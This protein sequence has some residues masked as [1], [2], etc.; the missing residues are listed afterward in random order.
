MYTTDYPEL[1]NFFETFRIE[2]YKDAKQF[3]TAVN[4]NFPVPTGG[5][6]SGKVSSVTHTRACKLLV[7]LES[8]KADEDK[9]EEEALNTIKERNRAL[10]ADWLERG[11]I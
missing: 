8:A 5:F 2:S 9:R 11:L 10:L 4:R 3:L 6:N 1:E 7:L